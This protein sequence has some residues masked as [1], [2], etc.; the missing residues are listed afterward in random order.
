MSLTKSLVLEVH[1]TPKIYL[2]RSKTFTWTQKCPIFDV[3]Y[4]KQL[5]T[6]NKLRNHQN[7]HNLQWFNWKPSFVDPPPGHLSWA[8][9]GLQNV[10]EASQKLILMGSYMRVAWKGNFCRTSLTKSLFL[11]FHGTPKMSLKSVEN[12][13]LVLNTLMK[14][15][16][17]KHQKNYAKKSCGT[18]WVMRAGAW[19]GPIRNLNNQPWDLGGR[20]GLAWI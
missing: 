20:P 17:V 10:S 15:R 6:R 19:A 12:A 9:L 4:K 8:S 18:R 3:S 7:T 11:L 5:L 13:I 14:W 1:W 16:L 2:K